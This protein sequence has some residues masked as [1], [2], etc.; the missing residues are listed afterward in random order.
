[1]QFIVVD[2][3]ALGSMVLWLRVNE[4]R[5]RAAEQRTRATE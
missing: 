2:N 5:A 4:Q 3:A 1:M